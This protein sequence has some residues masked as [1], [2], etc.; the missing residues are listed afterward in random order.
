MDGD[1]AVR[2]HDGPDVV[3][4]LEELDDGDAPLGCRGPGLVRIDRGHD[5]RRRP[6][7]RQAP[8]PFGHLLLERGGL[9]GEGGGGL[10]RTVRREP[11]QASQL[12]GH[13]P[14]LRVVGSRHGV[15]PVR[16]R[17]PSL[18]AR[19]DAVRVTCGEGTLGVED[20]EP[21]AVQ[22]KGGPHVE[23]GRL[24]LVGR[25]KPVARGDAALGLDVTPAC[26]VQAGPHE[27]VVQPGCER[28]ARGAVQGRQS[29]VGTVEVVEE[30]PRLGL[31]P[32]RSAVLGR[33]G[34]GERR[35]FA[36][37]ARRRLLAGRGR[38]GDV[39]GRRG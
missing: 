3:V 39:D 6:V 10:E 35:R 8:L 15:D 18:D 5:A 17:P 26:V 16:D 33:R 30:Q 12:A 23:A 2:Q 24:E 29:A 13:G 31:E 28:L 27:G 9:G 7:D 19:E 22:G 38:L 14:E 21:P 11:S 1:P 37:P 4:H 32:D 25:Q 34:A 36:A 20:G